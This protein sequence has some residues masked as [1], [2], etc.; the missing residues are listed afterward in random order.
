VESGSVIDAVSCNF[1]AL[2]LSS[3]APAVA[4]EAAAAVQR[5]DPITGMQRTRKGWL[6]VL[7]DVRTAL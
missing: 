2:Q 6:D 4:P 1:A 3:R 5:K 7:K